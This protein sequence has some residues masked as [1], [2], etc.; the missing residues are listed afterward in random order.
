MVMLALVSLFLILEGGLESKD[1]SKAYR[2]LSVL[3]DGSKDSKDL[4]VLIECRP[5]VAGGRFDHSFSV[6]I[7]PK[8]D[9]KAF[10]TYSININYEDKRLA[11]YDVAWTL[12]EL[13]S[14]SAWARQRSFSFYGVESSTGKLCASLTRG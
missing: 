14:A 3:I 12:D 6:I 7:L 1:G 9:T 8:E 5:G 13:R 11:G 10:K 2:D 4:S